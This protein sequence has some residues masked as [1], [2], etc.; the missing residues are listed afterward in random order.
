MKVFF[1]VLCGL[2]LSA[3][4]SVE[5][6]ESLHFSQLFSISHGIPSFYH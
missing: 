5:L 4:V 2:I 6:T 1:A 3:V